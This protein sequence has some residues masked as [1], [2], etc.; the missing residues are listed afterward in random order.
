MKNVGKT[1]KVIR[2]IVALVLFSL[3]F[4]LEGNAKYIAVLGIVPFYT[5][6]TGSCFL[7]S[8]L[9]ISTKKK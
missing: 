1:D 7:Y 3:F 4:V 2:F 9:G 5:A 6:I 8:I